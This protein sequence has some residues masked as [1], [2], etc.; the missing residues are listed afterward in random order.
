MQG[1]IRERR[2]KGWKNT[3]KKEKKQRR[4]NNRLDANRDDGVIYNRGKPQ[5]AVM[6]IN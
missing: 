4:E 1:S 6:S 2:T 3:Y 5:V